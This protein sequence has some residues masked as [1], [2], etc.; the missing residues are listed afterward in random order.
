MQTKIIRAVDEGGIETA[1]AEAA[2][3]LDRGD[4]VCIPTETVYGV[5]ARLDRAEAV[6]RLRELKSRDADKPFTLHIGDKSDI[7]Q[8]VP[9]LSLLNR[10]FL[11]KSWP[12]P[13]TVIFQ[14]SRSQI[15]KI[16][17]KLTG[18]TIKELYYNNSIGIRL[19]DHR[20]ARGLLSRVNGPVVVPSANPAG[21][22]PPGTAEEALEQ[23]EGQVDLLIDG[24]PARYA[25]SSTIIE[26]KGEE[27]FYKREGVLDLDTLE[28]MRQFAVLFVCTGNSCRS[29]MAEGIFRTRLAEKLSCPV[30]QLPEKGYKIVSAGVMA[31]DGAPA[32]AEAVQVC[33]EVGV[34][35]SG[36]HARRLTGQLLNEADFIFVMDSFHYPAVERL[37]PQAVCRTS[38]LVADRDVEDP[39]GMPIETY[40]KCAEQIGEGIEERI[41]SRLE[42]WNL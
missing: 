29:P 21:A 1:I 22:V 8:Y 34:D 38:L 16:Q 14:I 41:N 39:I 24:G 17:K 7:E 15:T 36:H 42:A 11:R 5:A 19:P 6:K 35:I 30:D 4:L 10:Q 32:S 23:L 13:L 20:I 33:R 3:T 40:R 28:Q 25:K 27:M 12:G 26:L 37:S 31:Y 9:D 2:E 18:N